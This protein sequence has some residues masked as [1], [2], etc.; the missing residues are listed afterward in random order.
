MSVSALPEWKQLLLE[1]KRRE[2]EE[3]ERRGRE[4]EDRLASMPAWKREIIQ[5]RKA[6][7]DEE[8]EKDVSATSE[9]DVTE[10]TD[11]KFPLFFQTENKQIIKS[12]ETPIPFQKNTFPQSQNSFKRE[13]VVRDEEKDGNKEKEAQ[14]G[15]EM[16]SGQTFQNK[17][18]QSESD[19]TAPFTPRMVKR[20]GR[21]DG[22][23]RRESV[24][25][26]PHTPQ[27]E[28]RINVAPHTP[29][30]EKRGG[31]SQET[32]RRE[33]NSSALFN[34]VVGLRTI[35]ANN[36]IIIEKDKNGKEKLERRNKEVL[37]DNEKHMRM[38]LR[39]F[40][41]GGGSVTEIRASEVLIIKPPDASKTESVVT[42]ERRKSIDRLE[43]E[44]MWILKTGI[45]RGERVVNH[46]KLNE[47]CSG[48]VSQLLSKFGEHRKNP[49]TRSKSSESFNQTGETGQPLITKHLPVQEG[50]AE[51]SPSYKFVPKRSF[52][53]SERVVC[54]Q[55]R[56]DYEEKGDFKGMER[57]RLDR[58][59][60]TQVKE[61]SESQTR[62]TKQWTRDDKRQGERKS[63]EIDEEE[64]HL[65]GGSTNASVKKHRVSLARRLP[66][67]Q[68]REAEKIQ[69]RAA[70]KETEV[71]VCPLQSQEECIPPSDQIQQHC[72]EASFA[73][74]AIDEQTQAA[75]IQQAEDLL[76]R[77]GNVPCDHKGS[78]KETD[79]CSQEYPA[80]LSQCNKNAEDVLQRRSDHKQHQANQPFSEQNYKEMVCAS[81]T[82][83]RDEDWGL[84]SYE[85][86]R[87]DPNC[88]SGSNEGRRFC[89]EVPLDTSLS[90]SQSKTKE[91]P[92]LL[93]NKRQNE[94][95]DDGSGSAYDGCNQKEHHDLPALS[96]NE[97]ESS[98]KPHDG[99]TVGERITE[100]QTSRYSSEINEFCQEQ[101]KIPRTVF[102]GVDV[103]A[104]MRRASVPEEDG[105]QIERRPSWKSGRALTR[106]ESLREKIRQLEREALKSRADEESTREA[107][108][109][110]LRGFSVT[111]EVSMVKT[112]PQLP[113]PDSV[114][115]SE[116]EVEKIRVV[117]ERRISETDGEIERCE[118]DLIDV[119]AFDEELDQKEGEE[120]F[121]D[122]E[123][124]PP[125]VSPPPSDSVDAMSRI[126][127]LKAVGSR[128]P[129]CIGERTAEESGKYSHARSGFSP[130]VLP[131]PA[132]VSNQHEKIEAAPKSAQKV[133]HQVEKLHLR[134]KEE[135][136]AK[137]QK[138]PDLLKETQ[139]TIL[140]PSE[141]PQQVR[142]FTENAQENSVLS[143]L[144]SIRSASAGLN[145]RGTTITIT[146]RRCAPSAT[147]NSTK[148]TPQ[149]HECS[150][151]GGKKR[152]PSA[153]EI[154]VIGG[155]Q[156]LEKSCLSKS[157][158]S[159]RM[160]SSVLFLFQTE[161]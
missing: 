99:S 121:F 34:S 81:D 72:L 76:C 27:M 22:I 14:R 29:Q 93:V 77:F 137:A 87:E 97:R 56:R 6:K 146:P 132:K 59:V 88:P 94:A 19:S 106:V 151:S 65:H 74:A 31:K 157:R 148:A 131:E 51:K 49:P 55:E 44:G 20:G 89:S 133:Q 3:K 15:R 1:R 160:V 86:P 48:R 37:E 62:I 85:E 73:N 21:G 107:A 129:V 149:S 83:A 117:S 9:D 113:V 5:R 75:L 61:L 145:K 67:R 63:G 118:D 80:K 23:D 11:G 91:T 108:L 95:E 115:Q 78:I 100:D 122:E 47:G 35:Q 38:D 90:Q 143:P 104:K 123:Y 154:Q 64:V 50:N 139:T 142:S 140:P 156:S 109:E 158:S 71:T 36:I 39:E 82:Q 58:R 98:Q 136:E 119:Q 92:P 30:M 54:K 124:R 32:D 68:E 66:I 161:M 16:W 134:D 125:S 7:Q 4:E 69:R 127:N 70:Q 79:L 130:D 2:E 110:H 60:K 8:K 128:S 155:Y 103:S 13:K 116:G 12:K 43:K 40:L 111:Q 114:L 105:P 41:A 150:P 52:S 126:Y 153:E 135:M 57:T 141:R 144:F 102:Y 96:N 10:Q 138:R 24:N 45:K 159:S 42:T 46:N 152:F 147:P 101:I 18:E 26:A 53:F 28:K 33:S 17:T 84:Q 25:V 120:E 112:S